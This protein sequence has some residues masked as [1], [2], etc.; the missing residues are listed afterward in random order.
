M[1]LPFK[2]KKEKNKSKKWLWGRRFF[3]NSV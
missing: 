2:E 3:R 1:A